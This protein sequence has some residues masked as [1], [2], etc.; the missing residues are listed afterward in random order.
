MHCHA[1]LCKLRWCN[2][3]ISSMLSLTQGSI[4]HSMLGASLHTPGLLTLLSNL[5]MSC[6]ISA[7]AL[8]GVQ[9][10]SAAVG[11]PSV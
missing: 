1:F 2:F 3:N 10:P 6:E 4:K 8:V 11:T 7:D 9:L 5:T